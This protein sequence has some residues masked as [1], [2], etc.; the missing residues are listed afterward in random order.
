MISPSAMVVASKDQVSS[1]LA[2]EA[3]ILNLQSGRYYGLA[4]VGARIWSL[5]REPKRVADVRDS[6]LRQ[7][8]VEF[9]RCERDLIALLE[10]LADEG[11][12]EV[13]NGTPP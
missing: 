1:D 11:L 12:I 2:G 9:A 5:L 13:T 6:I 4:E 8:D 7:Y 3:V 10:Q